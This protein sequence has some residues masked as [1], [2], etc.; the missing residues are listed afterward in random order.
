MISQA[1]LERRYKWPL[2]RKIEETK[3]RIVEWYEAFGGLVYVAFSGGRDSTV[4]LNI[5]RSLYPD[6]PAV[7]NNTGLEFPEIVQFVKRQ[8]NVTILRPAKNFR[9]VIRD[10]GYPVVSK[11][12]AQYVGE[13]RRAKGETATVR[14]R[15]TGIK[16]NG[17]FSR[18]GMI[19]LKWQFLCDAPFGVSDRCCHYMKKRPA[20]AYA[21]KT[22]R[23]SIVGTMACEARQRELTYVR[24]GCNYYDGKMPRSAPLS[25]WTQ[26]DIVQF[27]ERERESKSLQSI[28]R[29]IAGRGAFSACSAS[30]SSSTKPGRTV[31]CGSPK[32][33]R[34]CT[35]IVSSA[36]SSGKCS[37][38]SAYP[39]GRNKS[40]AQS[41]KQINL[42][43]LDQ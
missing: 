29:D 20:Q 19:P 38:I 17:V 14:L 25:F 11:R 13:V 5:V 37:T 15:L 41:T 34:N 32:L 7:F 9:E 33:T 10:Y 40:P 22:G 6:V 26:R 31:F 24:T 2:D 30:I 43:Y 36:S 3:K 23:A 28:Q 21:K 27:I 4:L 42:I 12:V 39:T 18:L 35:A 1:E 8:D 16:Q